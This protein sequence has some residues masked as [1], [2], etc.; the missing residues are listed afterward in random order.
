[1]FLL[2]I[3]FSLSKKYDV[4]TLN[5]SLL[6]VYGFHYHLCDSENSFVQSVFMEK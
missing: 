6:G 1:M 2:G 4:F 3:S 5:N